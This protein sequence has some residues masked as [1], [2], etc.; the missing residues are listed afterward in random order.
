MSTEEPDVHFSPG[1][2]QP[3]QRISRQRVVGAATRRET[4]GKVLAAAAAEFAERGYVKATVARIADRADVAVQTVYHAWGSK[5][6]ILRA[7]MEAAI[8]GRDAGFQP[9]RQ[10]RDPL[11][12]GLDASDN[13]EPGLFIA[14]LA[15]KYR[16]LAERSAT[17]WQ[18]YRDAAAVDTDIADD[19]QQLQ[20]IRRD[21]FHD[22]M[23][24]LPPG[25]LHSHLTRS[26]AA[27][28]AWVIASPETYELLVRRAGMTHDDLE[29][30][31]RTTLSSALLHDSR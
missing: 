10:F 8:V 2:K 1:E 3:Q 15:R 6:A 4:R 31:V 27:D 22:V 19:W 16:A 26:Q 30:W 24:H 21:A 9:G 13:V 5:R 18:T 17:G 7:V 23:A 25:A 11:I 29:E 28:T 12:G 14:H 20:L